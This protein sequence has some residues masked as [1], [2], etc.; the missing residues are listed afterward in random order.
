MYLGSA[1]P[2]Q[3]YTMAMAAG[4]AASADYAA[5]NGTGLPASPAAGRDGTMVDARTHGL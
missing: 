4:T 1:S 3:P 5:E 2:Y